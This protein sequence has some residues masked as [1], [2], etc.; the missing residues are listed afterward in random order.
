MK[1][2]K[3]RSVLGAVA[4]AATLFGSGALAACSSTND[5][6]NNSSTSASASAEGSQSS[7][8][9][10]TPED[11][12]F[13]GLR[14]LAKKPATGAK[15]TLAVDSDGTKLDVEF[16]ANG[17]GDFSETTLKMS[18]DAD[19]SAINDIS[20]DA[21]TNKAGDTFYVKIN[22][23]QS[24][25]DEFAKAAGA[26][27]QAALF[28]PL[29]KKIDGKYIKISADEFGGV[30]GSASGDADAQKCI[31]DLQAAMQDEAAVTEVVDAITK[32]GAMTA[33]EA[34][35]ADVNGED[36]QGYTI[37]VDGDKAKEAGD[38]L[39]DSKIG[40]VFEGCDT[41]SSSSSSS[42]SDSSS[43]KPPTVTVYVGKD[44]KTLNRVTLSGDSDDSKVDLDVSLNFDE[45][46]IKEPASGDVV[47]LKD[48]I[49]SIQPGA[50]DSMMKNMES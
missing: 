39:K 35:S 3:S 43:D 49:D 25:V 48:A 4:V 50:Y 27:D 10:A 5:P 18:I 22:D 38:T 32:S 41:D 15:G 30:A 9:A 7:E 42:S 29:V 24:L 37:T 11:A 8:A 26:G 17:G 12:V 16:T 13:D 28:D 14:A 1:I 33:K 6:S 40:K 2:K 19:G 31:A 20:V 21:I 45:A 47:S 23:A 44:S 34:D 46:D 36:S